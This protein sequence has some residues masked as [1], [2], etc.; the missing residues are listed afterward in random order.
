VISGIG[1]VIT[2]IG[3]MISGIGIVI[4]RI[5]HRDRAGATCG[6]HEAGT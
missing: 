6:T 3:I 1:I 4:T 2:R 5:A